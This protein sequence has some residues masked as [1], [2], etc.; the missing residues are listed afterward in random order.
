[1]QLPDKIKSFLKEHHVLTLATYSGKYPY[2]ANCFYAYDEEKSHF[3]CLSEEKTKHIKDL[4]HSNKVAL[5]IVLETEKVGK[6]Q[7][8]QINAVMR[9]PKDDTEHKSAKKIYLKR[10]PYAILANTDIWIIEPYFIKYTDNRLGF[11]KKIIWGN[12][13][14]K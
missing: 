13:D 3:I 2:C 11:G 9:K 8:A 4:T 6:I 12:I 14:A 1:M 10:F 7:G 5:S